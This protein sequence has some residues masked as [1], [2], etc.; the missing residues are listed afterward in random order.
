VLAWNLQYNLD[1][2]GTIPIIP[3]RAE[4]APTDIVFGRKIE[5]AKFPPN[6]DAKY[7]S[8]TLPVPSWFSSIPA[9]RIWN[10]RLNS[11]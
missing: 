10:H 5:L 2:I 3:K 11:K 1:V 9:V 7:T 6:P 4:E 8:T